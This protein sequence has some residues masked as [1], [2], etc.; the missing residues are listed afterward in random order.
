MGG[1]WRGEWVGGWVGP[2]PAKPPPCKILKVCSASGC[3][4]RKTSHPLFSF[5]KGKV[6]AP[7]VP[8]THRAQHAKHGFPGPLRSPATRRECPNVPECT[9]MYPNV[10]C[11]LVRMY[12]RGAYI[13]PGCTLLLVRM[14]PQECQLA[15]STW[16]ESNV[17]EVL[18]GTHHESPELFS[19]TGK[20]ASA[21][22]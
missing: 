11:L 12:P 20:E 9:R 3:A 1:W 8:H 7:N 10:P 16:P 21:G 22:K 18:L 5:I 17:Y 6:R 2:R 13:E 15:K 4:P 14:Y 19:S